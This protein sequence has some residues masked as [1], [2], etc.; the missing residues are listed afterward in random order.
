MEIGDISILIIPAILASVQIGLIYLSLRIMKWKSKNGLISLSF[1]L[2]SVWIVHFF[3]LLLFI[4]N[5]YYSI[6]K[7]FVGISISL[8]SCVL[9]SMFILYKSSKDLEIASVIETQNSS[10]FSFE[11]LIKTVLLMITLVIFGTSILIYGINFI[12]E[13][14]EKRNPKPQF[15]LYD[16]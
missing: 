4:N 3:A 13:E 16:S 6:F 2:W 10:N 11:K 15:T 14:I 12:A 9:L 5:T 8:V 1:I 7:N